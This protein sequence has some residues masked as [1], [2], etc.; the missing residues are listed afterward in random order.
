MFSF[1]QNKRVLLHERKKHTDRR[2]ASRGGG[3]DRQTATC[4]NI[5]F[6]ILRMRSVNIFQFITIFFQSNYFGRSFEKSFSD[7]EPFNCVV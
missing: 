7:M 3:V 6:P 1:K 5:T 4:E 2:V